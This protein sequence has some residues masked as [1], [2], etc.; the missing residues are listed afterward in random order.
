MPW[1]QSRIYGSAWPVS[2]GAVAQ[3]KSSS[4]HEVHKRS[5]ALGF[6][7]EH[8]VENILSYHARYLIKKKTTFLNILMEILFKSE[9]GRHTHN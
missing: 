6:N 8:A 2:D 7:V 4:R 9:K 1:P 3:Q 5:K